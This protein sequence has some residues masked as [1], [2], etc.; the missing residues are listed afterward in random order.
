[1]PYYRTM[2]IAGEGDFNRLLVY[3]VGVFVREKHSECAICEVHVQQFKR[4][5]ADPIAM[6]TT[7]IA[8][9]GSKRPRQV[10]FIFLS[11]MLVSLID[12][13]LCGSSSQAVAEETP[14]LKLSWSDNMLTISGEQLPGKELQIWYLEAYCRAGSTNRPWEQTVIGHHTELLSASDD[15]QEMKLRCTVSDGVIVDHLIRSTVDEIDFQIVAHNPTDTASQ[16]DWAQ[17][18]VRVD[19]FTGEGPKSYINKCFIFSCDELARLPTVDWATQALMVPGQVWAAQGVDL[20]DINPRPLNP[21]SSSNGLM[22]CFSADEKKLLAVA[23]EPHQELFQGII[24]CI[25]SDFRIGGLDPGQTKRVHGKLY[26]MNADGPALL[27]RYQHDFADR[28][29]ITDNADSI[30]NSVSA[31]S[32]NLDEFFVPP[33]EFRDQLGDYRSVMQFD[34]GSTVQT[35]QDW[36]RRRREIRTYWQEVMGEWPEILENPQIVYEASEHVENFTRHRVRIEVEKGV[37]DGPHYLLIPDGQGPFPAVVVT[38]YNSE[39]SA[40]LTDKTRGNRDFGYALAKRGFVTLCLGDTNG[41]DAREPERIAGV[42]PLSYLAYAAANGS[43]FLANLPQVD[44]KRIGIIGH[45]FGGKWAMFASCLHERFA[46]AVWS[47]PGIVWNEQDP[48]ANYWEKWY[49]GYDFNHSQDT[50]RPAGVVTPD[51]R[52][53]GAYQRLVDAGRDMHELNALMAPRPFLVSGGEQDRPEHWLA[54]N[55]TLAV[56]RLLGYSDRVAMAMRDGHSPTAES[57]EQAYQFLEH[58]LK[59]APIESRQQASHQ[60]TPTIGPLHV[61]STNPRYFADAAGKVVFLA[62]SHT[63]DTLQDWGPPT[64]NF[65]FPTFLDLLTNN[66][67]NFTRLWIWESTDGNT[68]TSNSIGPLPWLRSG[69]GTATDGGPKFDLHQ[70]NDEFFM[71][72]R[73]RVEAARDRGVYVSIMLFQQYFDPKTHP[74]AGSNNINGIAA[75]V[76]G[77]NDLRIIHTLDNPATLAMQEAYVQK[78]IDT[79]N[80]LDNVLFEIGNE[81]ERHTIP[82]Q[83]H[84]IDLIHEYERAKPNQHPVGMTSTGRSGTAPPRITNAELFASSAEWISPHPESDQQYAFN[85]PAADGSKV[86]IADTDHLEGVLGSSE[87]MDYQ[88]W[89]WKSLFRGLQPILMDS[90]QNGIPGWEAETWNQTTNPAFPAARKTLGIA[91][92]FSEQLDLAHLTPRGDLT[93]TTYCLAAPGQAYVVYQPASGSFSID[94]LAATYQCNWYDPFTGKEFTTYSIEVNAGQQE[95]TPPFEGPAVLRL[96]ASEK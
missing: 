2:V 80:D 86:V 6:E 25:H 87:A 44:D 17:P 20:N 1:M 56:N 49:L 29:E 27:K 43:N 3:L 67:H 21:H 51:N 73:A 78:V 68:S 77:N 89:I 94:C 76:D 9:H 57:N 55:H 46:C 33:V 31:P 60:M 54:L 47:D 50:Q 84:M 48:N 93:S 39:D 95:F 65:D 59:T 8:F 11:V 37:M 92:R 15:G 63:W 32:F 62:G 28:A 72:L 71:R 96:V 22:G 7:M 64:P 79:V 53:T 10:F 13:V 74:F 82:W 24:T 70:F 52:R 81:F 42:Q 4:D 19:K 83:Y 14:A 88:Q 5:V 30:G 40:G 26:L 69:P 90:I 75:D 16:V 23:F 41:T 85:P 45:S 34:D 38:W 35:P 66:G 18:C 36:R 61:H 58:F 91:R 12:T